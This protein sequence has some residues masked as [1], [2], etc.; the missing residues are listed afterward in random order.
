MNTVPTK[1]TPISGD[2][3][4]L[5]ANKKGMSWCLDR[6]KKDIGRKTKTLSIFQAVPLYYAALGV[7]EHKMTVTARNAAVVRAYKYTAPAFLAYLQEQ[8]DFQAPSWLTI[9][10]MGCTTLS[11]QGDHT[12]DFAWRPSPHSLGRKEKLLAQN[13]DETV[14]RL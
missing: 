1:H 13:T 11:A 8:H 14:T 9:G 10:V 6:L 4:K 5:P 2:S 12:T 3:L 7:K